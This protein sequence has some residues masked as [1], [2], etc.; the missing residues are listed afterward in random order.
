M[1]TIIHCYHFNTSNKEEEAAYQELRRK[2]EAQGLKC[3]E[4]WGGH[5]HYLQ[6]LDGKTL[7]LETEFLFQNQWNT[8][9]LEEG[10][11]GYRVFD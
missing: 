1:Q 8:A 10:H 7:T 4:S 2:L 3:H 5:S 9:P 6:G 11:N